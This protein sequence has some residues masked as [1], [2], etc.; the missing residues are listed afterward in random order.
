MSIGAGFGNRTFDR[1]DLSFPEEGYTLV[2][3]PRRARKGIR[4]KRR[5]ANPWLVVPAATPG[6]QDV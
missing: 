3:D 4:A 6:L 2:E 1:D 5:Q